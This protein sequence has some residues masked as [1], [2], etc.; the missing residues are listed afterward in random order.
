VTPPDAPVLV[1]FLGLRPY[2]A[3]WRAM[4]DFTDA[5][6]PST[7]DE[8][9]LLQHPPV[10]TLGQA[11]RAVHVREPGRIEVV[12]TDR[13][14]QVTYHGPGQ[15][16]AYLLFDLRRAGLG[17][18]RLVTVLEDAV[19]ALLRAHGVAGEA[20]RDAP[21]VYVR[22]AKVAALGLR[23]RRGCC[24]HGLAL[25]VDVDLEPFARID[26]CGYPGLPVTR[27]RDLGID[28]GVEEVGA[29]LAALL[30]GS[31]GLAPRVVDGEATADAY[32]D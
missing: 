23:V 3:T 20:R 31:L 9:W 12:A 17:V 11:G 22:G 15:L 25:N 4:R 27:L 19:V 13:G 24:Y 6:G 14:G 18:R 16:V 26:P 32:T 28:L 8:L 7:P 10:Y 29:L 2:H 5:R 21:G 1:R 30:A